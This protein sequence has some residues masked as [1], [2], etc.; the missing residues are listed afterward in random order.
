MA[1]RLDMIDINELKHAAVQSAEAEI[2][3]ARSRRRKFDEGETAD[4]ALW[5][6]IRAAALAGMNG[7]LQFDIEKIGSYFRQFPDLASRPAPRGPIGEGIRSLALELALEQMD[8]ELHALHASQFE[9]YGSDSVHVWSTAAM[10][11]I[12]NHGDPVSKTMRE[13]VG[14]VSDDASI[15][16]LDGSRETLDYV[17]TRIEAHAGYQRH[18]E[19]ESYE[20]LARRLREAME[21]LGIEIDLAAERHRNPGNA[22]SSPA[23]R[24]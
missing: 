4:K 24:S 11:I 17:A 22:P 5:S 23:P 19:R 15:D 1:T 2:V 12:R 13:S 10:R 20:T 18:A 9:K 16:V 3:A 7:V 21:F 6:E 14:A 8:E